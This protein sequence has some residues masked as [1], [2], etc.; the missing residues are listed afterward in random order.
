MFSA[1]YQKFGQSIRNFL[2]VESALVLLVLGIMVWPIPF[3][4][5]VSPSFILVAIYYW[6]IY[7]PDLFRPLVVFILGLLNDAIH[8]LPMGLSALIF[9]GVYQ[10]AFAHRRYFV[11]QVFLM[12]WFGFSLL[13]FLAMFAMWAA[14]SVFHGQMMTLVPV[15]VQYGLTVALFPL[16]AWGLIKL[17]R[18]FLSHG[19]EG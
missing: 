5:S 16:P 14:L 8:F 2:P 3:A 9:L 6:A 13:A 18:A 4:G 12:L 10:L 1:F 19:A 7:R 15:F 17:Q 11:G